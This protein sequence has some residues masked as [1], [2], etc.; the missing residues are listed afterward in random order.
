MFKRIIIKIVLFSI[1]LILIFPTITISG[2]VNSILVKKKNIKIG[3]KADYVYSIL[4]PQDRVR[5][6]DV[7]NNSDH[8]FGLIVT[9]HYKIDSKLID[10]TFSLAGPGADEGPYLVRKIKVEKEGSATK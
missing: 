2:E 4:K 9:Q 1:S 5:Q 8:P 10:I 6:P 3:N 7:I